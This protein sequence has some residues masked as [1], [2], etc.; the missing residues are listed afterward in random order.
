[1]DHVKLMSIVV[2]S[3]LY[4]Y[5]LDFVIGDK[6]TPLDYLEVLE[7]LKDNN[8]DLFA[9]LDLSNIELFCDIDETETPHLSNILQ[10]LD[11]KIEIVNELK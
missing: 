10:L 8:A 1:M 2:E 6:R 7:E 11:N 9:N 3:L 5:S 4:A